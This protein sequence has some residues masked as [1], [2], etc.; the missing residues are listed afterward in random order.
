[1]KLLGRRRD[2]LERELRATLE[3]PPDWLLDSLAPGGK[4]VSGQR[5]SVSSSLGLVAVFAAVS[6]ISETIGS[7]PLKVYRELPD[8]AREE[9]KDHRAYRMLHDMPNPQT[10]APRFWATVTNHLLLWGNAYLWQERDAMSG[11]VTTLWLLSPDRVTVEWNERLRSKRF[12]YTT[13]DGAEEFYSE[14][15]VLHLM[16]FSLDGLVGESRIARCRET[17]GTGLARREFEGGFYARGFTSSGVIEHPGKLSDFTKLR[18]GWTAIYGGSGKAHQVAILEEGAT[19]KPMVA[20]LADL[21]FVESARLTNTEVAILF[22]L[23]PAFLAGQIGDSLTYQTVEGNRLQFADSLAPV[24]NNIARGLATDRG[25]FPFSSWFPEFD[26]KALMRGDSAARGA[27]YKALHE[28]GAITSEEIRAIENFG[29]APEGSGSSS[30]P[31]PAPAPSPPMAM[32]PAN[33]KAA[34]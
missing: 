11:L 34:V 18:E 1:M 6:K 32:V 19:F 31:D 16:D 33:G 27:F 13:L 25:L 14:G 26:L 7:L 24:C 21:Q 17:I 2:R 10:P 15:T 9:A 22:N 29:P 20:P 30:A 5:V 12:R 23:P 28:V 3:N 8:D 4:S